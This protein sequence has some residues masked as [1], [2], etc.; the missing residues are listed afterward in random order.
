MLV[1]IDVVVQYYLTKIK[2]NLKNLFYFDFIIPEDNILD[3]QE[4]KDDYLILQNEH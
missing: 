4:E 2:S 1:R 3:Q